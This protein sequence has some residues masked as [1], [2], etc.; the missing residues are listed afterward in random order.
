MITTTIGATGRNEPDI[1][2]WISGLGTAG[3]YTDD[4]EGLCYN[5]AP[6]T[7]SSALLITG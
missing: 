4:E 1:A 6:F 5:D 3:T 2:S 7:V